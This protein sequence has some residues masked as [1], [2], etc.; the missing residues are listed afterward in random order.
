MKSP[1]PAER[2]QSLLSQTKNDEPAQRRR[3]SGVG[4]PRARR[5]GSD[6]DENV[7]PESSSPE[8][9]GNF[10]KSYQI[11]MKG[12]VGDAVGNVRILS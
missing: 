3:L 1:V 4:R 5:D 11:D 9:G 12:L 7:F 8:E 6:S 10:R 2:T